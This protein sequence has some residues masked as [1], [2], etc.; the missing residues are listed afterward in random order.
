MIIR[1]HR[2]NLL[3][4]AIVA[5][6]GML[7]VGERAMACAEVK[8]PKACCQAAP[9]ADCRCCDADDSFA[10]L[11][12]PS[13]SEV[14]GWSEG[15]PPAGLGTSRSGSSCE[16]RP[17]VPATPAPKPDSRTSDESRTDQGHD[18]VI[19]YLAFVPRP[20]LPATRLISANVSTPRSPLY[21]RTLHLLV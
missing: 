20:S 10:P 6:G 11:S 21:L 14:I 15:S 2:L 16:C 17:N 18:E 1:R 7:S 19:T 8:T 4:V 3:W 12:G 5:I 9:S 13:R